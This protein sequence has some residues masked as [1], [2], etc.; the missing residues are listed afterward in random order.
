MRTQMEILDGEADSRQ[1]L[2]DDYPLD[3]QSLMINTN[4]RLVQER[5][6]TFKS[7]LVALLIKF[8]SQVG[9]FLTMQD[10]IKLQ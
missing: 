4:Y 7:S 8:N 6:K 5:E 3:M 9:V 2:G 1:A 10:V